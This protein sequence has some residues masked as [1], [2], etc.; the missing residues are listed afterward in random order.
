MEE[1]EEIETI[2][3]VNY[4]WLVNFQA[5]LNRVITENHIED[6]EKTNKKLYE[7]NLMNAGAMQ[8]T[9]IIIDKFPQVTKK[10]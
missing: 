7:Q 6:P 3:E 10:I 2:L 9:S 4:N 8:L 1:K 5:E